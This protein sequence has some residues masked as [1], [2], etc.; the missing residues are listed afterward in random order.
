[1]GTL[2]MILALTV[3]FAHTPALMLFGVGPRN[4]VQLF[5]IISGFLISY[6]LLE[7]KSY[8]TTASFYLNRYLRL[9]PIYL[10]VVLLSLAAYWIEDGAKKQALEHIYHALPAGAV[11]YLVFANLTLIAQDWTL[12][13]GT[14]AGSVHFSTNFHNSEIRLNKALIVPPAWTLSLELL[15]YLLA[16]FI[17]ARRRLIYGLIAGSLAVRAAL[18]W[19]G[20]G[21]QDPWTYRFFPAELALF[22]TGALSHQVLLPLYRRLAPTARQSAA[23]TGTLLLIGASL[24]YPCIPGPDVAKSLACLVLFA[25][26]MPLAFLFQNE[27]RLDRWVG[28]LSYPIYIGHMLVIFLVAVL[29]PKALVADVVMFSLVCVPF[30]VIFAILLNALVGNPVEAIRSRIRSRR[31]YPDPLGTA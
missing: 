22:L 1:M 2:R 14:R 27:S 4:A 21:T 5:Y 6:V 19:L 26:L 9:Y 29:A 3:V 12:F 23:R 16:P 17:L 7:A 10:V 13:M 18:L 8:R 30:A 25:A 31:A 28:G 15:F 24:L 20:L 11:C